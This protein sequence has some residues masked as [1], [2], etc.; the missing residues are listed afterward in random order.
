MIEKYIKKDGS[1]DYQKLYKEMESINGFNAKDRREK[2]YEHV[3]TAYKAH[4][5]P[6]EVP[7]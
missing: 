3:T 1:L 4:T 7:F 2:H 6:K 5:N